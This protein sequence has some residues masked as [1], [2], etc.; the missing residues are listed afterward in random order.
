M[1]RPLQVISGM[2]AA[3][4]ITTEA[5]WGVSCRVCSTTHTHASASDAP[6]T[7]DDTRGDAVTLT[8]TPTYDEVLPS[9]SSD[10]SDVAAHHATTR[11]N[12][13]RSDVKSDD[14]HYMSTLCAA[15]DAWRLVT[16]IR[17]VQHGH[18]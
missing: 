13:I 17:V 8:T 14:G 7:A 16:D 6:L 10:S 2:R 18:T 4:A 11:Q 12:T 15:V 9:D 3:A 5:T 1:A